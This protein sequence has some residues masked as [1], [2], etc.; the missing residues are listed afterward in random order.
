MATIRRFKLSPDFVKQYESIEPSWGFIDEAGNSLGEITFLRSY[1][2]LKKDGTKESWVDTCQRIVEGM[3]TI[4]REHC[5]RNK[6]PWNHQKAQKTAQDAFDRLY[7][8]KWSPPG[9]GLANMGADFVIDE[10]D[11]TP[12]QNCAF[13]ST[14]TDYAD[15][16]HFLMLA[17]M[18]GVGVGSDLLGANR[19]LV[20]GTNGGVFEYVI[21]DTREGWAEALRDLINA[22]LNQSTKPIFNYSQIRP[23][24]APIARFGGT[25]SGPGVL[26]ELLEWIDNLLEQRKGTTLSITD[27]AD[28]TNKIGC[29]VVSGSS[30][31]SAEILIGPQTDDYLDLKNYGHTDEDGNWVEG[32][33]SS[34]AEWAWMSNN[35]VFADVGQNYGEVAKRTALNGEPGYVWMD[36]TRGFGRMKDRRDNKDWR[37]AGYN[38]CFHPDTIIETIEGPKRIADI[39]KPIKVYTRNNDGKLAIRQA[40]ASWISRKNAE[41]ITLNLTN[42]DSLTVTPEHKLMLKGG[43]WIEAKYLKPGDRMEALSRVRRG[44][45]YSGVRL[46]SQ[47]ISEQVMEHRFVW[48]G[49]NGPI[50]NEYD[51]DH[52]NREHNDNRIEEPLRSTKWG[53]QGPRIVS[54]ES[55]PVTDVYD[56]TVEE[57][58]CMI[59]NGIVAHNCAEQPLESYEMCVSG[60]TFL[61]TR[62]GLRKI[63]ETVGQDI[64]IWNGEK[65][66]TVTPFSTGK[67]ALYRVYISDGSYL[68][69][70]PE[71]EWAVETYRNHFTKV[72]TKDLAPG[73]KL[74]DFDLNVGEI[75]GVYNPKAYT[76][77]WFA[78]NGCYSSKGHAVAI[79]KTDEVAALHKLDYRGITEPKYFNR[80]SMQQYHNVTVNIPDED[81]WI[82][83]KE[84]RLPET[85]H[86]FDYDSLCDFFGGWID[87]N[88]SVS[89]QENTDN[90]VLYGSEGMLREAHMLL[91]RIGINHASLRLLSPKGFET[92][93]GV[94]NKD[95][96]R[97]TIPS[98]ESEPINTVIKKA[99]RF[100]NPYRVNPAH[101]SSVIKSDKRQKIVRIEKIEDNVDTYCFTE[102]ER[103]MGVFGNVLTHQ[104]TLVETYP[105]RNESIDDYLKTLK[106]AYLYGKTVTL[107]PTAFERT[108]AVMARNRRIGLSQTGIT[109]YVE[110]NGIAKWR[111]LCEAGYRYIQGKNAPEGHIP[112]LDDVY[113]DWLAIR[114]SIRTT[115]VKPSGTVSLL[116]GDSPGVHWNPASGYYIRRVNMTEGPLLQSLR[117][118][119]YNVEESAYSK[120]RGQ[121]VVSFP[122]KSPFIRSERDV[123]IWEK[124]ALAAEAQHW[125]SD[126]SVSVTI[127]YDPETE[128]KHI[129]YI[130]SLYEGR[131]KTVSF[132]PMAKKWKRIHFD[133]LTKR[134]YNKVVSDIKKAQPDFEAPEYDRETITEEDWNKIADIR[135][136]YFD[137]VYEQMPYEEIS[138]E[139]YIAMCENLMPIDKGRV[140]NNNSEEAEGEKFCTTDRCLTE[141]H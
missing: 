53:Y 21:P 47:P 132:L 115:T 70:T 134:S 140:Y 103:H 131:L 23:A 1:S 73:M 118:A 74:P 125:W 13:V 61:Q 9:R 33:A 100:G 124:V 130:L 75:E 38:P 67:N 98:Y 119:G 86:N 46:T 2:R 129:E 30:R 71:H 87:T 17:S 94:R 109:T 101:P 91:R 26:R 64:D 136:R 92:P 85:V 39:T 96:Y 41:T 68:D 57:T 108:N 19:H 122:I 50:E 141:I 40:S 62:T 36:T 63:S 24:G 42:G 113:S 55:G 69:A 97:L 4:Q 104:C 48:E 12:L 112:G 121:Y 25:A 7:H 5:R 117:E 99:T 139:Q 128:G 137:Q 59:A 35:S 107:L 135:E 95:L 51:I 120:G 10:W 32:P 15:A 123:T 28:I 82:L 16:M 110:Q 66:S 105:T 77:G 8:L 49:V 3:F 44:W 34:R 83:R 18:N 27:I 114:P 102:K 14:K 58:H 22:H 72:H 37:A 79:V 20:K 80:G 29:C 106:V 52:I 56:L 90:Y 89:V 54:I 126:N 60:D 81:A 111:E 65:W 76:Y 31:R 84:D 78:G 133:S 6:L 127:S 93:Y 11:G 138:E 116:T 43:E 45:R 88:G